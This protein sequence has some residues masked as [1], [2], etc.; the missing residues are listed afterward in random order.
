MTVA[1][2]FRLNCDLGE[3]YGDRVVGRDSEVMP[4]LD[5]ANIACGFH[6]G[7]PATLRDTITLA[8]RHAVDVGAHPSYPDLE[9]FGRRSMDLEHAELVAAIHYQLSA[10]EGMARLQGAELAHVKPH[11]ALYNDM[12]ARDA[13]RAAVIEAVASWH[14]P[15]TLLLQATPRH[16]EHAL[17]ALAAGVSVQFEA[18]ADRRYTD[19]GALQARTEAGAV[20]E[21]RAILDQVAQLLE[22]GTVTTSGGARIPVHAQ[23]L[24]VHGDN[25][26]GVRAI[27]AIRELLDRG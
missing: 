7:D 17:E 11:G 15:L 27:R 4:H 13:V 21:G 25:P 8:L 5:Q 1:P 26:A 23:T 20:L 22:Q 16:E 2:R 24:C 12:M 3:S 18:F 19:S 9:G 14:R 6:G 10:V